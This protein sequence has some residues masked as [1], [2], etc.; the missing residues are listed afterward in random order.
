[1]TR[2]LLIEDE[3]PIRRFLRIALHNEGYEVIEVDRGRAGIE[4]AINGAPDVVILDLGLPDIDG[5]EVIR[6]L[7]EW[8]KVPILVLTV[9]DAEAEK[10]RALDMGAE[11]YVTKP[12]ATGELLARLRVLLRGLEEREPG[13]LDLGPLRIDFNRRSVMI[14]GEDAKLTRKEFDVLAL[15]AHQAGRL[16]THR[17]IL[18]AVWGPHHEADTHYLRIVV[19]HLRDKLGDDAANPRVILTDPGVGYRLADSLGR[20]GS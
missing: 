15:L 9:R 14:D 2:I 8:S 3:V 10:I 11:D 19:G 13:I 1:M 16:V 6:S 5:M 4:A 7:R 20:H 17:Q 12:F 18:R